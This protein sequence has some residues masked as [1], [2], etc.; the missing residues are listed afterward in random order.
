[1]VAWETVRMSLLNIKSGVIVARPLI[2]AA[3]VINAANVLN[4][5]ADMVVTSGRDGRH[6]EGSLHYLDRALD[7]RTKHLTKAQKHTL[8]AE[9]RHRLGSNYDVLL[10]HEGRANEH[11][12][13]EYDLR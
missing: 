2:I 12:H 7:F 6:M 11:L 3:G 13:V 4:I 5:Q 10:E 9:A 1:M 8:L